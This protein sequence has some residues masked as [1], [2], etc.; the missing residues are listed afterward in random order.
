MDPV[1]ALWPATS[2]L[3]LG[4]DLSLH[5]SNLRVVKAGVIVRPTPSKKKKKMMESPGRSYLEKVY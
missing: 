4:L 3:R 1:N 5:Q 2:P